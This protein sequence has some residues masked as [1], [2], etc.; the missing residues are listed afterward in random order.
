MISK[1]EASGIGDVQHQTIALMLYRAGYG[2]ITTSVPAPGD[3]IRL[4]EETYEYQHPW[5][6][7][8]RCYEYAYYELDELYGNVMNYLKLT[9]SLYH[10][11]SLGLRD[12][13]KDLSEA[14]RRRM[15]QAPKTK[16]ERD[17]ADELA[18]ISKM[19]LSSGS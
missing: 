2:E 7:Q 5:S 6:I 4:R 9:P 15:E 1:L 12:G 18:E 8:R 17:L 19:N 16:A 13:V 14:K 11:I 10:Q 3:D